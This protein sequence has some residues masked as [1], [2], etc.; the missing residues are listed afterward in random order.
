MTVL[1]VSQRVSSIKQADHIIVLEDGRIAGIGTHEQ[2]RQD[3]EAYR[4]ICASQLSDS[5]EEAG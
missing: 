5:E 3:C 2:L 1:L 4:E